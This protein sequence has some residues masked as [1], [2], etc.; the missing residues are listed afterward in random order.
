MDLQ[1][2]A[3]GALWKPPLGI[4]TSGRALLDLILPPR[5]LDHGAATQTS[6]LSAEAWG[7]I[8]FLEAPVCDGCGAPFEHDLGDGVRCAACSSRPRVFSR[9][10]A[11]CLYDDASRDLVLQLKHADRTELAGLLSIWIS[12]AAAKLIAEAELIVPVPMRPWR[13]LRRRYNQ[14][15]ELA[16]P[17][18][19][20]WRRP[21]APG[22]LVRLKGDSQAGKSAV[23]RRRAVA[24]AFQVPQSRK[25]TVEGRRI[26]LVDDVMTTGATVDACAKALIRAGAAGV[27]VAVIARVRETGG[28]SI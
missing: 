18:A 28:A 25:K 15:A 16:R 12:R 17:L 3:A 14:A 19:R 4:R 22:V 27:N 20:R 6:G 8:R 2:G 11:A 9:A 24:G 10:R 13:L 26:L 21:Y 7:R 5:A 1:D 23:G